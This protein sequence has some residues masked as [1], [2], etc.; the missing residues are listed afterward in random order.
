[1]PVIIGRDDEEKWIDEALS[2]KEIQEFFKP[3]DAD[4]MEAYPVERDFLRRREN[5][6][7]TME[8]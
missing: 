1:M 5:E 2:E 3:F 6:K 4:R 7:G 8:K